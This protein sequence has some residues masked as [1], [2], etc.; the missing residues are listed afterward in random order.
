[1][2]LVFHIEQGRFGHVVL[3]DLPVVVAARTPGVMSEGH[4]AVGLLLDA[5]ATPE[6]QYAL[7][8]IAS[9]LADG[10]TA[11]FPPLIGQFLGTEARPIHYQSRYC[12]QM[13]AAAV[14]WAISAWKRAC[15]GVAGRLPAN[16][17][18]TRRQ[19]VAAAVRT[20]WRGVCGAPRER[21]RCTPQARTAGEIVPVLPACGADAA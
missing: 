21:A 12:W 17:R 5:Q 14:V 10:P 2:A 9:G 6:Q 4:W 20:C 18:P 13:Q 16:H 8:A 1:V 3:D 19:G 7:I 11:A 15:R